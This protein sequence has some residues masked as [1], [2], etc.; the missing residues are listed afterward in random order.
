MIGVLQ[1]LKDK[2]LNVRIGQKDNIAKHIAG[3]LY[4]KLVI[5]YSSSIHFDA[6]ATRFRGQLAEN[7]KCLASSHVFPEMNHNEITGWRNPK[8]LFKD[9]IVLMFRDKGMH[10]RTSIRMDITRDILK[11]EQVNVLEVSSRGENLLSRIF[12]LIY[13]GDFVS[14]YLAILYGIDP[15]PVDRVT[16]L[17]KRLAE[18][19]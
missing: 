13:I 3:K 9:F 18:N 4:N 2:S 19:K 12:S 8:K 16:Y 11:N 15:T 17:K 7:S 6:V 10:K 14:F 1:E 5:I